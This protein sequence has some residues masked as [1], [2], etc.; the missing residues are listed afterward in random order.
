MNRFVLRSFS[1]L[2]LSGIFFWFGGIFTF[3]QNTGD[4]TIGTTI[5]PS[6]WSGIFYS[7][8]TTTYPKTCLSVRSLLSCISGNI[9][10]DSLQYSFAS[11]SEWLPANCTL[12]SKT[13]LHSWSI[14]SY[15]QP[16]A[17][18]PKTCEQ[19]STSLGCNN[20]TIIGNWNAFNYTTCEDTGGLI[21]GIDLRLEVSFFWGST[22]FAQYSTPSINIFIKN[23]WTALLQ[24]TNIQPGFLS[25]RRLMNNGQRLN[26]YQ[27]KV[28]SWFVINPG[29]TIKQPIVL[30]DLFT[31]TL[32]E[33]KISCTLSLR[34]NE[35]AKDVQNNTRSW[36]ISV[37]KS[38]RFDI[39][40]DRSIAPIKNNLDAPEILKANSSTAWADAVKDFLMTKIMDVLVPLIIVIGILISLLWFYKL[41]F[42]SDEKAI[43]DG[44]KYITYWVIWII[45]I[46]SAK[47][48]AATMYS[49]IFSEGI[50]GY[51]SV[52][53][54][55]IAQKV[56]EQ[57][58]FPFIKLAIYLSLGVLFVILAS[59]TVT[60]IFGSDDDAKKKAGTIMT[61]NILWMI[62]IIWAKQV[63][64]FIY[65]K[66]Q[67][68]VKAV[69]NLWEVGSGVLAN[70]NLPILYQVINR[71]MGLASLVILVMVL[72]QAFQLLLK[73]DS[74]DAMKKIKNSLLYIFI[75]ILIIGTG[76]IITNFLIIN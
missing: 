41:L 59:R 9:I 37:V 33:K 73:P 34:K 13:I 62:V 57:I 69:S 54:Y 8:P 24:W 1:F 25:C 49:S 16:S 47:Y 20:G 70:K 63:V 44:I 65:G 36:A 76:Y 53:W 4:C 30:K 46:M 68:V 55:E 10:G 64:E 23:R 22:G 29:T 67:D 2:F 52:Q 51:W 56:Y 31:Q 50:L 5:Y 74:P 32:W 26:I 48:I 11:C 40:M 42:S 3:A 17:I 61:R 12:W 7:A 27:S 72:I 43:G 28:I 39:A 21:N 58:A 35:L 60:F 75:G 45:V 19:Y 18:Y 38:E 14:I 66:Q 6:W 71:A 15:S